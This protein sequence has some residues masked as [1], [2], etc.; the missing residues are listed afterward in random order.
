VIQLAGA[1]QDVAVGRK[2]DIREVDRIAKQFDMDGDTRKEFGDYLE[3]CKRSGD[4]GSKND[5]GDFTWSE[6]EQKA[7]EFLGQA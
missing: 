2:R 7:R 4:V 6:L 5:R 3:E 1:W